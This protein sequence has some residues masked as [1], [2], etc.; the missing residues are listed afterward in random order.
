MPWDHGTDAIPGCEAD[1]IFQQRSVSLFSSP[2]SDA[3]GSKAQNSAHSPDR[4]GI[5][6]CSGMFRKTGIE[7]QNEFP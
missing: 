5:Y 3:R 2:F 4:D 6:M 1:L 7:M